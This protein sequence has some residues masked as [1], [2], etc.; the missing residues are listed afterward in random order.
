MES[1]Y[2]DSSIRAAGLNELSAWSREINE[3][4]TNFISSFESYEVEA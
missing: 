4:N 3:D 2:N 1:V